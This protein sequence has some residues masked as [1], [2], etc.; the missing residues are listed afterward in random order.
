M[1]HLNAWN[2]N[3]AKNDFEVCFP[4]LSYSL[5]Y[6]LIINFL[7]A[8]QK[9]A[10]QTRRNDKREKQNRYSLVKSTN[11]ELRTVRLNLSNRKS[12]IPHALI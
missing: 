10:L 6:Y 11:H 5:N 8:E 7:P 2:P 3:E 1:A 9:T 4:Y 12:H